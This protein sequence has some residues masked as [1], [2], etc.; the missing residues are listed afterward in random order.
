M[1][2]FQPICANSLKASGH[3]LQPL[4]IVIVLLGMLGGWANLL[5][6]KMLDTDSRRSHFF[7]KRP[8]DDRLHFGLKNYS[9]LTTSDL[10]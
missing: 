8:S 2:K 5:G 9:E 10:V 3:L 6:H 1:D 4:A 7:W